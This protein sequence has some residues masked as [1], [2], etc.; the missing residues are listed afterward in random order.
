M[1]KRT[2]TITILI[3][4]VMPLLVICQTRSGESDVVKK[5]RQVDNQFH[6]AF[7]LSDSMTLNRLLADKFIWTHSTGEIQTKPEILADVKSGE[8]KYDSL[9]MD[10]VRIYVYKNAAVVNGHS[11]RNYSGEKSFQIRYSVFYVKQR[12]K[13]QAVAFHTSILPKTA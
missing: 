6:T 13:W 5:I 10:D 7:R 12:G 11:T 4:V 9:I 8:L 1:M 2:I 3:F